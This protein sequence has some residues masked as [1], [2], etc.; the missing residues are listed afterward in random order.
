MSASAVLRTRESAIVEGEYPFTKRNFDQ[1]A[2]FLRENTGISLNDAKA[3]LVYSRLAKRL[4]A[5]GIGDFDEYCRYIETQDGAD[6]RHEMVNALTTNVTRFFREPHHFEYLRQ[7]LAPTLIQAAK[8]GK[9]VRLWSAAC[10]SGEEPYSIALTM[11]DALPDADRYD[12]KILASDI[13]AKIL[14]R[15]RLGVY[16]DEA[17]EPIPA[18]TRERWLA[19][20]RQGAAKQWRVK[21][22]VRSLITFNELNLIG[23]WP[24]RGQFDVIFCRNVV[25]YFEEQTQALVWRRFREVMCPDARL[26]IGH[27]E[28]IDVEGF[29]S[30]GLTIYKLEGAA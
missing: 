19:Q 23:S 10:S 12:I 27:S 22:A 4:R 1:I 30:A 16:R 20:E 26:F 9:R 17:I 24:M 18:A 3:A 13:D 5:L 11:L 7:E 15:A 8:H 29:E 28:R 6:E 25:I 2:T 14:A 21:D